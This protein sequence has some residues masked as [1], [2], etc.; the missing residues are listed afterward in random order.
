MNYWVTDTLITRR[1]LEVAPTPLFGITF[2][3]AAD[4]AHAM[5]ALKEEIAA[6][7][8]FH[9]DYQDEHLIEEFADSG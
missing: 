1:L 2:S 6:I 3:G 7:A 8:K 4:V 5:G 9:E